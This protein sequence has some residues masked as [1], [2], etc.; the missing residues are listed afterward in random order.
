VNADKVYLRAGAGKNF[1]ALTVTHKGDK[2]TVI[3][4]GEWKQVSTR[5]YTGFIYGAFCR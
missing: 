2:L 3:E 5:D 1:E 4:Q